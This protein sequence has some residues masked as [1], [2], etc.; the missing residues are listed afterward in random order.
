MKLVRTTLILNIVSF[1]L[2]IYPS[3]VIGYHE[4]NRLREI[5]WSGVTFSSQSKT[6]EII[7]PDIYY[8]IPDSYASSS[9][10]RDYFNF[11][12]SEF[13]NYLK[14]RGFYIADESRANY[15]FTTPSLASA[16][17]MSYLDDIAK[18][19][20]NSEDSTPLI[21]WTE[22]NQVVQYLKSQGYKYYH[23]GP[24]LLPTSFNKNADFNY[25]NA[26]NQIAVSPLTLLLFE[27]TVLSYIV[28]SV[29]CS[30]VYS[31]LCVGSLNNRR[32]HYNYQLN[33]INKVGEIV[34]MERPKFVFYHSLL[35][36]VPRVFEE[37][38]TYIPLLVERSRS[39]DENYINQLKFTNK[40]LK[41]LIETILRNSKNSPII[42]LQSDEGPYPDR[43]RNDTANFNWQKATKDELKEKFGILN[44]YYLPGIETK[45]LKQTMSSI[46]TFRIIF[47][48]YFGENLPLLEDI[49]Y[50]QVKYHTPYNVF[51][52]TN[53]M[54]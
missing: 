2:L 38:G 16:L 28:T 34:D 54:K 18:M 46:N 9:T 33:Q 29:D 42:I 21:K 50:A 41:Q 1:A 14:T 10:L 48:E 3:L 47:N 43:F 49:N 19:D 51:D 26:A 52:V 17:N 37:D 30:S 6:N 12:N 23:F 13:T 31:V 4:V 53:L 40:V 5:K 45:A 7:K 39:W 24:A 8:I 44:A 32:S 15:P 20:V 25:T 27:Q 36:H 22:D 11:D 35:T